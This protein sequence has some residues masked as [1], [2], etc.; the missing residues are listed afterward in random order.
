MKD[1]S[2]SLVQIIPQANVAVPSYTGATSSAAGSAGLVPA[3]QSSEREK[4]LRG[5]GTW[6]EVSGGSGST[7]SPYQG[8]TANADGVAGLVPAATSAQKDNY[9]KGDGTWGQIVVPTVSNYVGATASASGTAG[10][11]PAATSAEKDYCLKGDGTWG[12]VASTSAKEIASLDVEPTASNTSDLDNGSLIFWNTSSAQNAP[13]PVY[14]SGNQTIGGVKTF[15]AGIFGGTVAMSGNAID[16]SAGTSFTKT[17]TGS[18][19]FSFTNVPSDAT[20][21]VT[22]ILKN[23]GNYT[24][25]WPASVKWTEDTIP[26][27]MQNGTD[28]LTFITCD[29]GLTWY[30]TTTCMGVGA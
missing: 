8:A 3:A 19:T 14:T 11:V 18:T 12:E 4:F 13:Q 29:G 7:S 6:Q 22:L 17:I 28:V 25:T 5:D 24:V 27:L 26:D 30:G 2:G 1:A 23:G 10:L 21:C 9:L 15:T 16:C 20:C